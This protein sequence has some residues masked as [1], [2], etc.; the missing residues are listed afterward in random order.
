M[1]SAAVPLLAASG[2]K[3][4]YVVD[5]PI[6]DNL[7]VEFPRET[8]TALTGRS[9]TGK[10]TLLY[11]LGLM[12]RASSGYVLYDG[13]PVNTLSDSG[14]ARLR[15]RHF[16]FVFQDAALDPTRTVLDNIVETALYRGQSRKDAITQAHALL[17]RFDV[18]LRASHKPGQISGGQ[19]QRIALCRALLAGPAVVLADEPTGNLDP[20]TA[21]LV[22]SALRSHAAT[23][24]TVI[25]AT[26][27]PNLASSCDQ[28]VSL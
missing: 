28:H 3:F 25:I 22:V 26:H 5:N 23:G 7:H 2:L 24:A 8:V 10:S 21:Q 6:I 15:A 27:D 11:I 9:G 12:L 18:Q 20:A 17:E 14:R 16:G 4:S 19:A 13:T 1:T